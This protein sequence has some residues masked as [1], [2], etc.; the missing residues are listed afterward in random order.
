MLFVPA[1]SVHFN[2]EDELVN[3]QFSAIIKDN[4]IISFEEDHTECFE[5]VKARLKLARA[6]Y[7]LRA[8]AI[9]AMPLQILLL[10]PILFCWRR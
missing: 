9:C 8:R 5:A 3:H 2:K 10:I 4:L 6:L 1:A 7:V